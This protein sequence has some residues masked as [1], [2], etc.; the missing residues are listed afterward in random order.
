MLIDL[1]NFVSI[2]VRKSRSPQSA[3][4]KVFCDGVVGI[5]CQHFI[6]TSEDM[7][8]ALEEMEEETYK[9]KNKTSARQIRVWI[10][11]AVFLLKG[12]SNEKIR[13]QK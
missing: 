10:H 5:A 1:E 11:H 6:Q 3:P 7:L 12:G 13:L 2:Y 9:L 4:Y 8:A